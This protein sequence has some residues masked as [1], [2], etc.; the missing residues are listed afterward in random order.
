MFRID[1]GGWWRRKPR[2]IA[3]AE[4][5]AGDFDAVAQ[6]LRVA[7]KPARKTG[8]V[9][10][11]AADSAR[12]VETHWDGKETSATAAAGDY[13]VTNMSADRK[14][15]RDAGGATNRYVI[16]SDR[17]PELYE[18]AGGETEFGP[19]YRARG[20]VEVL[21]LA[22]GF[23]ILAPWG[24]RQVAPAGYLIKNGADIYGNNAGTF[25]ATYL[26]G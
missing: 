15:L 22:G 1:N 8:F 16:R 14:V 6:Q 20:Q 3:A 12:R 23:D 17:F 13:I 25:A 21:Y 24:Q 11:I 2:L 18:P 19:I 9:A 5:D 4:L 10:A 26:I 7:P